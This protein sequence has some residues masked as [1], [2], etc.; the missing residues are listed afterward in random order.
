LQQKTYIRQQ[1][2]KLTQQKWRTSV[3]TNTGNETS[4]VGG[5]LP[6]QEMVCHLDVLPSTT[7]PYPA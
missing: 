2:L 6:L 7:N 5:G 1:I 4:G 3:I